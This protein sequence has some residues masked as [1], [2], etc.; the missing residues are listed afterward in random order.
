MLSA[1]DAC[2]DRLAAFYH[3]NDRQSLAAAVAVAIRNPIA[4]GKVRRWSHQEGHLDRYG[5]FLAELRRARASDPA[6]KR[7]RRPRPR[8]R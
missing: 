3:W 6:R 1:T 2:R 7:R 4:L 5:V 8:S